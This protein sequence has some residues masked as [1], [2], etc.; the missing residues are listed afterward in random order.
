LLRVEILDDINADYLEVG[1]VDKA[2]EDFYVDSIHGASVQMGGI[3]QNTRLVRKK[4]DH[5]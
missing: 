5:L 1:D 3:G 2:L 4:F